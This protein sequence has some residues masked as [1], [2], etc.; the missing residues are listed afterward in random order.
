MAVPLLPEHQCSEDE[1]GHDP[2]ADEATATHRKFGHLVEGGH[3]RTQVNDASHRW[4]PRSSHRQ[5]LSPEEGIADGGSQLAVQLEEL[6]SS[7]SASS[8]SECCDH[9]DNA[10][11]HEGE[12]PKRWN[13]D[14]EADRCHEKRRHRTAE[15][16]R[17]ADVEVLEE[18][19]VANG[20]SQ[21]VARPAAP[22]TSRGEGDEFPEQPRTPGSQRVEGHSVTAQAI[23][24]ADGS[25][26][27]RQELDED[28]EPTNRGQSWPCCR[29]R[30]QPTDGGHGDDV[31]ERGGTRERS[32]GE[33]S[34]TGEIGNCHEGAHG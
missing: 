18:V 28:E 23:G 21:Q 17:D 7:P 6:L 15:R 11:G 27:E 5:E 32:R 3:P 2:L 25:P 19:D 10:R 22:Q 30:E 1:A 34:T 14:A 29:P 8:M 4:R 12:E 20:S 26:Q 16:H 24:E 13:E 31:A 33:H 9:Q